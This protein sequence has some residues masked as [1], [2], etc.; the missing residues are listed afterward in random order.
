M[1]KIDPLGSLLNT[2]ITAIP[3][4]AKSAFTN[5]S[6]AG[7][8]FSDGEVPLSKIISYLQ[9]DIKFQ[10]TVFTLMAYSVG[11]GFNNTANTKI[12]AGRRCLDMINEFCNT[13]DLDSIN[14]S[15]GIDGWASG[16]SF[17]NTVGKGEKLDGIYTIPLSSIKDVNY[18]ENGDVESYKHLASSGMI[19]D[20]AADQIAHFKW[21][22]INGGK[23]GEGIGQALC[24]KGV[25]YRTSSGNITR[26]ASFFEMAE[27]MIDTN[28]KMFY[29]GQSRYLITPDNDI[30][31][32]ETAAQNIQQAFS[33]LDPLQHLTSPNKIKVQEIALASRAAWDPLLDRFD[34]EFSVGTK[35]PLIE[36]M[37]TLDFSYASS[38]TALSTAFPLMDSFSRA[39]S[40]FIENNIYNPLIVQEGKNPEIVDVKINWGPTEKLTIE[41]IQMIQGILNQ[42][43]LTEN[44]DPKDII[45]MLIEC[46][47]PLESTE[48]MVGTQTD[49]QEEV[50]ELSTISSKE[51]L[52]DFVMKRREKQGAL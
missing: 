46:G 35:S 50:N 39:Y 2:P 3:N 27:I 10:Y 18:D 17:L 20:T 16:N 43:N 36:L 25:G 49:K 34:K 29:S 4:A 11:R 44:H 32:S 28:V 14:Q 13:W 7:Y 12:P 26:R 21:L 9:R 33:K 1:N 8:D 48:K 31:L 41:D 52:Y 37:S 23:F 5:T 6:R 47:V 45:D 38:K 30:P 22:P 19:E 51:Q 40:R 15:I 42:P 24:R